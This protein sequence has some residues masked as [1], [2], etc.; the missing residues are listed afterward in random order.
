MNVITRLLKLLDEIDALPETMAKIDESGSNRLVASKI[1]VME[2]IMA[3]T[4]E[5]KKDRDNLLAERNVAF[6]RLVD[7]VNNLPTQGQ[8]Q[9]NIKMNSITTILNKYHNDHM[10]I[11]R[12]ELN[13]TNERIPANM[14]R[15]VD[16]TIFGIQDKPEGTI[17]DKLNNN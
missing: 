17:H 10:A 5:I 8:G 12:K 1:N 3:A 9:L 6:T 14:Q 13:D 2:L 4:N 7:A 11:N 15:S 16:K